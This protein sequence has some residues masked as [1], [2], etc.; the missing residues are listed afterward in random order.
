MDIARTLQ[1]R[2]CSLCTLPDP[3][4]LS[5]RSTQAGLLAQASNTFFNL[6]GTSSNDIAEKCYAITA[7]A[8]RGNFTRLPFSPAALRTPVY[9]QIIYCLKY[10][11]GKVVCQ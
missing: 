1:L 9:H 8:L 10:S 3:R 6:L 2:R 5:V 4:S 7:T 11:Q